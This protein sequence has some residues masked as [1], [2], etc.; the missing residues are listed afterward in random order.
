MRGERP[1]AQRCAGLGYA[2]MERP[3][4]RRSDPLR[5]FL[6]CGRPFILGSDSR[7]PSDRLGCRET[8]ADG[9]PEEIRSGRLDLGAELPELRRVSTSVADVED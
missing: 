6:E 5:P 7:L 1:R 3:N 2:A 9:A 8:P 4:C